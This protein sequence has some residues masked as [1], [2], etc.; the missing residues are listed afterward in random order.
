[1]KWIAMLPVFL[2]LTACCCTN[3]AVEYQQVVVVPKPAPVVTISD[4]C[5]AY[6]YRADPCDV[7]TTTTVSTV[8]WY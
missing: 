5:G 6:T 8:A 3:D 2:L 1:M 4:T 7:D